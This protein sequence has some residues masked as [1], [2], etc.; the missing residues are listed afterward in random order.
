M[1]PKAGQE[2]YSSILHDSSKLET[3]ISIYIGIK[4]KFAVLYTSTVAYHFTIHL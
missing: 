3:K 1:Y 2:C 4:K